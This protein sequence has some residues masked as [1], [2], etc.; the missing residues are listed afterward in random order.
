[1]DGSQCV[2]PA[3]EELYVVTK[4]HDAP[5]MPFAL[6]MGLCPEDGEPVRYW[7]WCASS[8]VSNVIGQIDNNPLRARVCRDLNSV[9]IARVRLSQKHIQKG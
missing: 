1:M 2:R 6:T 9:E 5:H 4:P 3:I 7:Y 8:Y